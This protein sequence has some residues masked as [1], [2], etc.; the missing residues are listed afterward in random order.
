MIHTFRHKFFNGQIVNVVCDLSTN[1]PSI[2]MEPKITID[3]ENF[4]EYEIWY[5]FI[6]APEI[7]K[8][9]TEEQR[10]SFAKLGKKMLENE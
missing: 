10:Q 8:M 3:A 6:V 1:V 2:K 7:L 5:G 9:L 4:Y